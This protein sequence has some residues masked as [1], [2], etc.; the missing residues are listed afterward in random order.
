MRNDKLWQTEVLFRTSPTVRLDLLW[1]L[2]I[3]VLLLLAIL[4]VGLRESRSE[5]ANARKEDAR[6]AGDCSDARDREVVAPKHKLRWYQYSLRTLLMLML[7]TSL[8]MSCWA[9]KMQRVKMRKEWIEN[10]KYT[11]VPI[12][13]PLARGGSVEEPGTPSEDEVMCA[14]ELAMPTYDNW[15]F[16]FV[17]RINVLIVVEPMADYVDVPRVYP[18][19]GRAQLHHMDYKC[20]VHFTDATRVAAPLSFTT[21]VRDCEQEVYVDHN[22]LHMVGDDDPQIGN[23]ANTGNKGGLSAA[24]PTNF[25]ATVFRSAASSGTR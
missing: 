2:S 14:V 8:A 12:L 5:H 7:V 13:G 18:M 3:S 9:V 11:W 23:R 20:V 17:D 4:Y 6:A 15:P 16:H 1:A 19:V 22:H 25:N 10:K 24:S 21:S